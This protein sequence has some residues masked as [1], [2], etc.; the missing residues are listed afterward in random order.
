MDELQ[1][2]A[3]K[4]R[5]EQAHLD[6]ALERNEPD[7]ALALSIAKKVRAASTLVVRHLAE[8]RD[9]LQPKEGTSE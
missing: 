8:L 4:L 5:I 3:H 6:R 7:V 1:R 9:Q 2:A